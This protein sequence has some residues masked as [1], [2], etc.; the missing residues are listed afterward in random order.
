[1]AHTYCPT[2]ESNLEPDEDL[3]LDCSTEVPQEGW[4]SDPLLGAA[5]AGTYSIKHRLGSGGFGVVYLAENLELGGRRAVKVLHTRHVHNDAILRRFKREAKALYRLQSPF[6]VRLERWGRSDEG[7]Y[8]LVMEFAEG[9]TLRD[10]LERRGRLPEERALEI[11]RQVA[12]ALADAHE[13]DIV[14]RDLKPENIVVRRHRHVGDRIAVLDFGIS[15]ILSDESS[16]QG[17]GLVGTPAYIAPELWRP[18]LGTA[19]I[20]ADLWSL[21]LILYEMLVG[22]LPFADQS[23]DEPMGFAYQALNLDVAEVRGQLVEAGVGTECCALVTR[24]LQPKPTDRHQTPADLLDE[25]PGDG[26]TAPIGLAETLPDMTRRAAPEKK[27]RDTGESMS[28]DD[29]P[30]EGLGIDAQPDEDTGDPGGRIWVLL[31]ALALL[32]GIAFGTDWLDEWLRQEP[33]PV[34]PDVAMGPEDVGEPAPLDRTLMTRDG[35]ELVLANGG[36][37]TMGDDQ[38]EGTTPAHAVAV[39]PFYIDATDVEA[40]RLAACPETVCPCAAGCEGVDWTTA[41][42]F[43]QWLG[44]RLPTEAEWELLART[45]DDPWQLLTGPDWVGDWF[46]HDFYAV[47]PV[48]DPLGPV[49]GFERVIRGAADDAHTRH[50]APPAQMTEGV[51][52]RCVAEIRGR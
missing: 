36:R 19:N 35:T 34:S 51:G 20:R 11:A 1:M 5:L 29:L 22:Q 42:G 32:G 30:P 4:P 44:L 43:C 9:E 33:G 31:L 49:H 3:C 18:S 47:S 37:F 45:E 21:G 8:Y 17:S 28:F 26:T 23:T 50:S 27:K 46:S 6:T 14:H 40:E 52:F 25:L 48:L 41:A 7:H 16:K 38:T 15:K 24:L 10:L 2:C 12:V 39:S 13:L